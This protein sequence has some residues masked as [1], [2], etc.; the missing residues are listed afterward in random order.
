MFDKKTM[1]QVEELKKGFD[2]Q[3]KK[4]YGDKPFDLK[5]DGGLPIKPV[6]GPED[7]QDLDFKN[8]A[9]PGQY[10]FTRGIYPTMYQAQ[11]W[12]MQQIHGHGTP[13]HCRERMDYLAQLGLTGYG[14]MRS[15]NLVF[16]QVCKFGYDPDNPENGDMVGLVGVNMSTLDDYGRLLNG[17]DLTKTSVVLNQGIHSMI[18]LAFYIVYGEEQGVPKEKLR[19][20]TMNWLFKGWMSDLEMYPPDSAFMIMSNFIRWCSRNMPKWNTTNIVSYFA[21]EAGGTPVQEA[22]MAMAISIE[23][24]KACIAAGLEPDEFLPRFGFQIALGMDIFE[25]VSK[26]RAMRRMWATINKER[27]GAKDKHSMQ[28]RCHS[29]TSAVSLT[30]QQPYVNII[31]SAYGALVGVLSGVNG[32]TINAYDE[33]LGIPTDESLMLAIR[34]HQVALYETGVPNVTDPLAGS[35]YVES[36]TEKICEEADKYLDKI[37]K[38]GGFKKCWETGWLR[39][40]LAN[41]SYEWRRRIDRG[42]KVVVGLN[43]HRSEVHRKTQIYKVDPEVKE[44]CIKRIKE[45][46]ATR[47]KEKERE[48]ALAALKVACQGVLNN[49]KAD[50]MPALIDCARARSSVQEMCDVMK[51]IFGWGTVY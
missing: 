31:R 19:G 6:Y 32:M 9:Y 11:P 29:Q 24:T 33:A 25:H 40:E 22:A 14:E 12:V 41:S 45:Y 1:E 50:F 36:L 42:E 17:L 5:T 2:A 48:Q 21:E 27:F 44:T 7:V 26:I 47:G 49:H 35:Y 28:I 34:T 18:A 13:E 3:M 4:R 23:L 38:L 51:S 15:Y 20:N 43:K 46:R 8:I 37:E 39:E 30:A 16:D 10:P